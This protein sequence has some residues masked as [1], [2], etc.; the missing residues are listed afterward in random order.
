MNKNYFDHNVCADDTKRHKPN[1]ELLIKFL[2]DMCADRTDTVCIGDT[3]YD[4]RCACEAG[5]DFLWAGWGKIERINTN[6]KML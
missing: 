2:D 4:Y 5:V 3:T 6:M 1:G